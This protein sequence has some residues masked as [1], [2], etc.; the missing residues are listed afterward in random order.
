MPP[1]RQTDTILAFV[2]DNPETNIRYKNCVEGFDIA[3]PVNDATEF[4]VDVDAGKRTTFLSSLLWKRNW[5]RRFILDLQ[6][7]HHSVALP[8]SLPV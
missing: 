4:F 2:R 3:S 7:G 1:M 6:S 8:A 5:K